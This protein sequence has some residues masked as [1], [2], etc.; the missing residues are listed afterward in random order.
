MSSTDIA[1]T[2]Q[3]YC[4]SQDLKAPFSSKRVSGCHHQ[5][6]ACVK[7]GPKNEKRKPSAISKVHEA[8][9]SVVDTKSGKQNGVWWLKLPSLGSSDAS[10]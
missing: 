9:C 6:D 7:L 5:K 2:F 4:L 1:L 3:L 8:S 10:R